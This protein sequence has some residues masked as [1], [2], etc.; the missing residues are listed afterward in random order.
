VVGERDANVF[1][2][3]G[4]KEQKYEKYREAWHLLVDAAKGGGEGPIDI[5]AGCDEGDAAEEEIQSDV[6]CGRPQLVRKMFRRLF[7][8]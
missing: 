8:A 7:Q 2:R 4:M 3:P 6:Q 1:F 5:Q